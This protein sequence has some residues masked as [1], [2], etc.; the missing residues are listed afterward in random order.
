[1][2]SS[3]AVACAI[4]AIQTPFF[5]QLF[6]EV[7]MTCGAARQ[8]RQSVELLNHLKRTLSSSNAVSCAIIAIKS[9]FFEQLTAPVYTTCGAAQSCSK[10]AMPILLCSAYQAKAEGRDKK[11]FS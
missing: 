4:I 2:R 5:A 8:L 11:H 7:Y 1:L 10:K 6:A 3:N 9:Q